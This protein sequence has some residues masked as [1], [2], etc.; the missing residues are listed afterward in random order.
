MKIFLSWSGQDSHA[1]AK[2]VSP[3]LSKVLQLVTTF[4]SSQ[5]IAAGED[6]QQK[7]GDALDHYDFG[8]VFL[9]RE[10][11]S[12]PWI[13]FE[14]GS[15]AKH[16]GKGRLIPLLCH[17]RQSELQNNPLTRF[18]C[19]ELSKEG[20]RKAVLGVYDAIA[21]QKPMRR[22]ICGGQSSKRHCR[23]QQSKCPGKKINFNRG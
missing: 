4:L 23:T 1:I 19:V 21:D 8:I 16:A 14:S 7:L 22:S 18:Q 17:M 2:I 12:A 5:D 9:T 20:M 6:W 3:W 13:M 11:L 15:L 10:N